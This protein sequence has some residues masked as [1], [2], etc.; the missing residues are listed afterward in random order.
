M[1]LN[2]AYGDVLIGPLPPSIMGKYWL[3]AGDR[4]RAVLS[5]ASHISSRPS[6]LTLLYLMLLVMLQ[7]EL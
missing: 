1:V 5:R 2:E 7:A 3:S 6:L 4:P